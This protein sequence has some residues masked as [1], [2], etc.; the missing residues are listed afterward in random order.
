MYSTE[1]R[2]REISGAPGPL[3]TKGPGCQQLPT[4]AGAGKAT[5]MVNMDQSLPKHRALLEASPHGPL[6][7]QQGSAPSGHGAYLQ[8][9]PAVHPRDAEG[10]P[11]YQLQQQCWISCPQGPQCNLGSSGWLR[12]SQPVSSGNFLD[13]DLV[14]I[15]SRGGHTSP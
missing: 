3:I 8:A 1:P 11:G 7:E 12:A 9:S 13:C 4:T 6:F 10:P 5:L 2:E 15:C 14:G